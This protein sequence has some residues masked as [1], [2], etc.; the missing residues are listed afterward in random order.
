MLLHSLLNLPGPGSQQKNC[1]AF[2][3]TQFPLCMLL[4]WRWKI[5]CSPEH[6][7]GMIPGVKE[8]CRQ[9]A[10]ACGAGWKGGGRTELA[11]FSWGCSCA[12]AHNTDHHSVVLQGLTMDERRREGAGTRATHL[13]LGC[14]NAH[15]H[16]ST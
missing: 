13:F 5:R 8:T 2:W 4:L 14:S 9:R 6:Y 1:T 12:H 7:A 11:G 16:Q 3:H 10:S 15:A